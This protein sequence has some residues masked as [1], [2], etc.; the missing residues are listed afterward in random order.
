MQHQAEVK[1][2]VVELH[3]SLTWWAAY[4]S[5]TSQSTLLSAL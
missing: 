2:T 5:Y 1:R 3:A 4:S